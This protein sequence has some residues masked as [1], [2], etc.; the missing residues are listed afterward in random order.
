MAKPH[1]M[2]EINMDVAEDMMHV[3]EGWR[4]MNKLVAK[5]YKTMQ[6]PGRKTWN[7]PNGWDNRPKVKVAIEMDH[8][9]A[10]DI[11]MKLMM[12]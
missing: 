8:Q 11:M 6:D 4:A 2:H 9:Q 5:L 7:A 12:Q 1:S 3:Y 10:A